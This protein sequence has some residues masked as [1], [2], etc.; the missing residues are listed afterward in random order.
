M[1][2]TETAMDSTGLSSITEAVTM[3]KLTVAS[4]RQVLMPL[5]KIDNRLAGLA[6]AG[7]HLALA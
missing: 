5:L 1:T 2:T 7:S 3:V 6:D 4:G